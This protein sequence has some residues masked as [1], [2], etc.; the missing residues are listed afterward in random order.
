MTSRPF[1]CVFVAILTVL[2]VVL[3]L[4]ADCCCVIT[5]KLNDNKVRLA[6]GVLIEDAVVTTI[7]QVSIRLS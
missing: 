5:L 1:W 2:G 3:S 7:G 6:L 4:A